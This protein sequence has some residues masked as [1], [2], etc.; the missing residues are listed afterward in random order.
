MHAF[1]IS[2]M[3]Q[4]YEGWFV[5]H[6][7]VDFFFH[8]AVCVH[9]LLLSCQNIS[10]KVKLQASCWEPLHFQARK[11]VLHLFSYLILFNVLGYILNRF[12]HITFILLRLRSLLV[13]ID[14]L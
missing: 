1:F 13:Q 2:N 4:Q 7:K 5:L 9:K 14:L 12:L 3:I 10:L 6:N 8:E 11:V